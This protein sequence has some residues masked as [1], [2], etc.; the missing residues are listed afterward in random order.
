MELGWKMID[1]A[2]VIFE[3]FI[4]YWFFS[5]KYKFKYQ[6][7]KR[8]VLM[9]IFP[10]S[11]Y[12]I[13][14]IMD[15][16]SAKTFILFIVGIILTY[17]IYECTAIQS[18]IWNSLFIFLLIVSES[19]SM[20]LLLFIH[21]NDDF[22]VFLDHS[23]LRLQ[24]LVLSKLINVILVVVSLKLIKV[25]RKKYTLKEVVVLLLQAFSSVLCLIMIVELSYYQKNNYS[26][27]MMLLF[28]LGMGV[29]FSYLISYY[30]INFYFD[31]R[32]REEEILLIKM[33]NEKIIDGYQR[34]ENNQQKVYQLYHDIKKHFNVINMMKEK[35]DVQ[36]YL[37]KCF[38]SVQD[39]EGK[40]QT[41]SRYIDMIL[42]DEWRQ[43]HELGI[44]V[45][46]AIEK[47]S[48][49]NVELND[50][51]VILG[52]ALENAR[53]AC[54]KRLESEKSAHMQ[55]KIIKVVNQVFIV[56]SNNYVGKVIKKNNIFLTCKKDKE[57]HGI[58]I[59]SMRSSVEKYQGNI[60]VSLK[61]D[62]FILMIMLNI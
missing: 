14:Y 20:G 6:G 62:K 41:G 33:R 45:Q 28:V 46:F 47:D 57:L 15:F 32:D 50:I 29:L 26:W 35:E 56:V 60:S 8:I 10:V 4:Y 23:F 53:E 42:Y 9:L 21:G 34:L 48:L 12:V 25:E 1:I 19:I 55:L 39:I 31:Y 49:A 58:G 51:V 3:T 43:A 37:K 36:V 7:M 61:D 27:S 59:K 11:T 22:G 30:F 17:L 18:L 54:E 13:Q 5:K 40:F 16:N 44:K 24:C 38:E 2:I 52:N